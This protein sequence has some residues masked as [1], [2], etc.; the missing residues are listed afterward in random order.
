[1]PPSPAAPTKS[2][3]QPIYLRST[4]C[5]AEPGRVDWAGALL[6]A[7]GV[8]RSGEPAVACRSWCGQVCRRKGASPPLLGARCMTSCR[9]LSN[10]LPLLPAGHAG[11]EGPGCKRLSRRKLQRLQFGMPQCGVNAGSECMCCSARPSALPYAA[12]R[13]VVTAHTT[14]LQIGGTW[15]QPKDRRYWQVL[16]DSCVRGACT[17]A[18]LHQSCCWLPSSKQMQALPCFLTSPAPPPHALS[19]WDVLVEAPQLPSS[20]M[21]AK[22]GSPATLSQLPSMCSP[23]VPGCPGGAAAQP[24]PV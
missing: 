3:H 7:W 11:G 9:S 13:Q 15:P 23:H 8:E 4:P 22:S 17:A 16:R 12:Q 2:A 1:M 21:Q 19:A 10:A 5:H 18:L 6:G 20:A 14:S 24:L